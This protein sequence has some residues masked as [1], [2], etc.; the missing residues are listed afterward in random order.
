MKKL[1]IRTLSAKTGGEF[2]DGPQV[3]YPD[4]GDAGGGGGG[5]CCGGRTFGSCPRGYFCVGITTTEPICAAWV[6]VFGGGPCPTVTEY[7]CI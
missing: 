3:L 6:A 2:G 1:R 7:E 5:G 4:Y